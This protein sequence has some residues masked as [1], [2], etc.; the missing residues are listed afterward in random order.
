M[1]EPLAVINCPVCNAPGATSVWTIAS[2]TVSRCQRCTH[3]FVSAGMAPDELDHAYERE[4]YDAGGSPTRTGYEDYL[5]NAPLRMQGFA[6]RLRELESLTGG[7]G[8]LL[9]FGCAV[10]L[11]VKVAVDAGWDAIGYERSTW[12]AAYGRQHFG[13]TIESGQGGQFPGFDRSFDLVTMW[14]VLEHLEDPRGVVQSVAGWL[15]PGG[16]LALNT[17]D[18]GSLGARLAGQ[19]WRHLAPPHH[20]QYFTRASLTELLRGAGFRVIARQSQGVMWSAD[21]RRGQLRG[22]R[23]TLDEVAAHWRTRT[24]ADALHLLDEIDIVAVLDTPRLAA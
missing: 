14:D 8:C 13:I 23:A 22:W 20:L 2:Y 15:K 5:A 17:V 10:G 19:H 9:D 18:S 6:K 11:F 4:Y 7:Q 21:R 12:A 24:V 3:L 16:V 1:M